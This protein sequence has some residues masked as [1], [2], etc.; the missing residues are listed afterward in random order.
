MLLEDV[1][2]VATKVTRVVGVI[3]GVTEEGEGGAIQG[4]TDG[5]GDDTGGSATGGMEVWVFGSDN[6]VVDVEAG[7]DVGIGALEELDDELC[8]P[9]GDP[10]P[11]D[12]EPP[13]QRLE[14]DGFGKTKGFGELASWQELPSHKAP[15]LTGSVDGGFWM[16]VW[17]GIEPNVSSHRT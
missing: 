3:L 15:D 10:P 11:G 1:D 13:E 9:A 4:V 14:D 6:G 16:M 7:V 12:E 8:P 5:E 2:G 17:P